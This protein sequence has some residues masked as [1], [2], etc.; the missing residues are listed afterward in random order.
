MY[1]KMTGQPS[2]LG[3][4]DVSFAR[5]VARRQNDEQR[6]MVHGIPDYAFAMDYELRRRLTQIPHFEAIC[7]KIMSTVVAY[8]TQLMNQAALA[9]TANQFPEIYRMGTECA[10]RLGIGVPNI[11][12]MNSVEIN[13]FTCAADDISP[14]I[15][16][17]SGLVERLT[18]GELKCVIA[19]ECG[20]IHNNHS[21]FKSVIGVLMDNGARSLGSLLISE[22]N[23]ALMTLW[24]RAGEVTADRAA[25]ICADRVEDAIS[26]NEKLL[27]GA[28]M[29]TN[30]QVNTEELRLQFEHAISNPARILELLF[31]HPTPV[32]RILAEKEFEECEVFYNWRPELKKPNA[33]MR[34]MA[35][36]DE[37]CK[38]IV[39][40]LNNK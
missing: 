39:N 13:A 4:I 18:P 3:A 25:M 26:V 1:N 20:H 6:H 11:F 17:H 38:K 14:I 19:H 7:H 36:T 29:N 23:K 33:V 34:T 30:Y 2:P 40:T 31:D 28:M 10:H 37:R 32:R 15:V 21:V 24:I 12:V 16:L 27:Y 9:V 8:Q 35:D 5:Y 22:A